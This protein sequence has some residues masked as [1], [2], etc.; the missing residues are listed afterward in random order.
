MK[1]SGKFD[2]HNTTIWE[3]LFGR[4]F[5]KI[6][7]YQRPY[8]WWVDEATEFW[9]DLQDSDKWYSYFFW[10]FVFN[11]QKQWS[12]RIEVIDWQQRILTIT[13]FLAVLR[14]IYTERW[15]FKEYTFIQ[16]TCISTA[17]PFS[18]SDEDTSYRIIP[19][20]STRRY[21]SK[22]QDEGKI[23]DAEPNTKEEKS[24]K[25]VYDYFKKKVEE[26]MKYCEEKGKDVDDYLH[27]LF[28]LLNN[29]ECIEI[30]VNWEDI[31]YNIFETVNARWADL[32]VWDLVKNILFKHFNKIKKIDTAKSLWKEL[33]NNIIECNWDISTFLRHYWIAKYVH[34]TKKELYRKINEKINNDNNYEDF[35]EELVKCSYFYKII[36][37]PRNYTKED[38]WLPVREWTPKEQEDEREIAKIYQSLMWIDLFRI[39]QYAPILLSI[40]MNYEILVELVRPTKIIDIL[41]RF[42]YAYFAICSWAARAIENECS[43]YSIETRTICTDTTLTKEQ[44]S[45]KLQ[46]NNEKLKLF[47]RELRPT[48]DQFQKWF[49]KLSYK[50]SALVKYTLQKISNSM[51]KEYRVDDIIDYSQ[52]NIE[53]ILPQKPDARWLTQDDVKDFVDNIWNLTL[54]W[55]RMNSSIWNKI[56]KDKTE[57]KDWFK[58]CTIKMTEDLVEKFRNNN[59]VWTETE[60]NE[61]WIELCSKM[62]NIQS[63]N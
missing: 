49:D 53:H 56:L 7:D 62:Y 4:S 8:S 63:I 21:F 14:D 43:R 32:T 5:F 17:S 59:Y 9:E 10:S 13:I 12:D 30:I 61:R 29:A 18:N 15:W 52:T 40:F 27:N 24:I 38:L 25:K 6:P 2:A 41:E 22:I 28:N 60:I 57:D 50:K 11:R 44:K 46:Q 3:M 42:G 19:W 39:T 58:K 37:N 45:I 16:S 1:W 36:L 34:I 35:L 48:F 54:I 33:E 20:E 23:K 51:E 47:L 31:A 55:R 26:W